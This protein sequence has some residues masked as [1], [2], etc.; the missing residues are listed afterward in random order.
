MVGGF[1]TDKMSA[2]VI[3]SSA[4]G[5]AVWSVYKSL[6]ESKWISPYEKVVLFAT[7]IERR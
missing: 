5:G 1:L 6:S 4:D 7:G 2:T 3:D